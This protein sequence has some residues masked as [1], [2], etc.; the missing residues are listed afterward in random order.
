MPALPFVDSHTEGEPTRVLLSAEGADLPT[1]ADALSAWK[2]GDA[3]R[4][5]AVVREPRAPVACVGA[6]LCRASDSRHAF[7]VVFFNAAGLLGMCGHATIGLATTLAARRLIDPGEFSLETPVGSVAVRLRSDGAVEFDNVE[8]Y[9]A[10]AAVDL[11][12]D[13]R[14]VRGDVAWGGNWFFLVDEASRSLDET[15][16]EDLLVESKAIRAALAAAGVRGDDGGGV[17]HVAFFGPARRPDHALRNFVLCPNDAYDRSPCG[18]GTSAMLAC[19]AAS[20]RLKPGDLW[21]Q[22]SFI[23][24]SFDAWY[25]P[26]PHGGGRVLPSIRGR[27]WIVAEGTLRDDPSDPT[28]TGGWSARA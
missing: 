13:G 20:G 2:R 25:R 9:R 24:S 16:A 21:R 1:L 12:V 22:E 19:L 10:Q 28:L 8:A 3:P 14:V 4:L 15:A 26:S 27:A 17:D 11:V 23:G 6:L 7:G 5:L 18:T